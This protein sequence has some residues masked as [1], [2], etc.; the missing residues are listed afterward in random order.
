MRDE[1]K[2]EKSR[3]DADARE[4]RMHYRLIPLRLITQINAEIFICALQTK[5][6]S[7]HSFQI[8]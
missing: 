7:V 5:N 2:I 4:T 1:E 3:L 6:L 8:L